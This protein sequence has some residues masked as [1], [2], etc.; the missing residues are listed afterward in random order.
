MCKDLSLKNIIN[1]ILL[2]VLMGVYI[3]PDFSVCPNDMGEHH[4]GNC[5]DGMM[6]HDETSKEETSKT[7][8]ADNGVKFKSNCIKIQNDTEYVVPNQHTT[9]LSVEQITILAIFISINCGIP[10]QEFFKTPDPQCRSGP[11]LLCNL[12]RGPPLV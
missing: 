2:I 7:I 3:L 4:H 1:S 12:L 6:K 10:E 9:K 5:E 8:V 11:P